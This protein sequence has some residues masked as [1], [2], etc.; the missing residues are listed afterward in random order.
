MDL[1]NIKDEMKKT[2]E[3]VENVV[4][5]Y[6]SIADLNNFEELQIIKN[7]GVVIS[8]AIYLNNVRLIDNVVIQ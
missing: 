1:N 2:I 5:D 7:S 3:S 4:I 6:L 8:G